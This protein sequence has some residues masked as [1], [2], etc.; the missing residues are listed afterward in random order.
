M[1][2]LRFNPIYKKWILCGPPVLPFEQIGKGHLLDLGKAGDFKVASM[3][4]DILQMEQPTDRKFQKEHADT[5][6]L[7]H[8]PLGDYELV[9]YEGDRDFWDWDKKMWGKWL[10]LIQHRVLLLHANLNISQLYFELRTD[11]LFSLKSYT[12]AGELIG[13]SH[14]VLE[15]PSMSEFEQEK[16]QKEELFTIYKGEYGW[17]YVPSAPMANKELWYLPYEAKGGIEHLERAGLEEL[18]HVLS[19]LMS[20][21]HDEWPNENWSLKL[22]LEVGATKKDYGWWLSINSLSP[23]LGEG[24][25]ALP[26]VSNPE[27]FVYVLHHL[28]GNL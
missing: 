6:H 15:S 2:S 25:V 4:R 3:P 27:G 10:S 1:Y 5:L 21:L 24:C 13:I 16:L 11:W 28:L 19:K 22:H 7:A 17:L 14:P 18:A 9:L 23:K 8:P 20:K 12:R 26:V